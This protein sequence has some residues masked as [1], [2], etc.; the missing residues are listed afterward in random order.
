[1]YPYALMPWSHRAVHRLLGRPRPHAP[2]NPWRKWPSP[3]VFWDLVERATNEQRVPYVAF[4][5]RTDDPKSDPYENVWDLF[6]YLPNHPL[7]ER[8]EFVDPLGPEIQALA[9]P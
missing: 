6:S 2:L 1:A 4:A 7:A 5:T 3:K 9:T 8:L